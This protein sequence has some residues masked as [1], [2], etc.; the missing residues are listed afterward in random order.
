MM[1][2]STSGSPR[3]R[4]SYGTEGGAQVSRLSWQNWHGSVESPWAV[5]VAWL[6]LHD[7]EL[8]G[9][10]CMAQSRVR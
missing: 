8:H 4:A 1:P 6:K 5:S 10:I 9:S 7:L 2:P 3:P